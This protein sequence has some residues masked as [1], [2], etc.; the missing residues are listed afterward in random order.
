MKVLLT[1][2]SG[3]VGRNLAA[4]FRGQGVEV[5]PTDLTGWEVSG[6]LL[7]GDFVFTRLASLDFD[8]IVHLAAITDLK[9]TVENPKLCFEVNCFGTLN[10]LELAL[11]K[12]VSRVVVASSANVFGAPK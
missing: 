12:K 9:R 2:A 10:I 1:G 4:Y 5:T 3:M 11:K 6:N 8:A 7:D